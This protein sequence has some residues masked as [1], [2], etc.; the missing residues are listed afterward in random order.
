LTGDL[1]QQIGVGINRNKQ[2]VGAALRQ[3]VGVFTVSRSQ[4]DVNPA[5]IW[6]KL[7]SDLTGI[8][9]DHTGSSYKTHQGFLSKAILTCCRCTDIIQ[10]KLEFCKNSR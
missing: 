5:L 2:A 1:G 9:D 8:D 10:D 4:V 7:R 3:S 6:F